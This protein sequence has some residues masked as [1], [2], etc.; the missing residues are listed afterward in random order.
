M[1]TT[2]DV[3]EMILRRLCDQVAAGRRGDW[4]L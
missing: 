3:A 1:P 2:T 4:F